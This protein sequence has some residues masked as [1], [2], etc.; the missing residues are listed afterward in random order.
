MLFVFVFSCFWRCCLF[1]FFVCLFFLF[2][3]FV[4]FFFGGGGLGYFWL[5]FFVLFL[6]VVVFFYVT[7][8][9]YLILC[10]V[11]IDAGS[12]KRVIPWQ[13]PSLVSG[14]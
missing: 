8:T 4:V 10:K 2:F 12:V 11:Y 6:F 3:F 9:N 14:R 13:S 1:F 7:I 5:L